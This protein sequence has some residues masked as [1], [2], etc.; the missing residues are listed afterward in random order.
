M[1]NRREMMI[2]KRS[3]NVDCIRIGQIT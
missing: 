1:D 3:E 2:N